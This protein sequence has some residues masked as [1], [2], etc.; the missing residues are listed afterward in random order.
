LLEALLRLAHDRG[1][2]RVRLNAQ[3]RAVGFY[4]R[5]GFVAEGQEFIEAGIAHR[6]MWC[7]VN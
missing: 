7:D 5:H 6:A 3:S 4:L 2:R 1:I